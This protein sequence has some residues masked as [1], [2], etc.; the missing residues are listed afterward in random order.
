[1]SDVEKGKFRIRFSLV[2][3]CSTLCPCAPR[4]GKIDWVQIKLG[5]HDADHFISPEERLP[6][7]MARQ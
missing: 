1:V 5:K 6:I 3:R 7:A 4:A 2:T